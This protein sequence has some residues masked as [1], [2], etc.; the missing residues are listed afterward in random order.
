MSFK[1]LS[2]DEAM[3]HFLSYFDL[4]GEG[5]KVDRIV[6]VFARKYMHDN[7]NTVYK[8][9]TAAYTL[10]YLLMMLQTSLHNPQVQEKMTLSQFV[11]LARGL[12]DGENIPVET[13]NGIYARVQKAPLAIPS[14]EKAKQN[15]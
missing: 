1:K 2:I 6:Q 3:K 8:S 5:Q 12:N 4:P 13:L 7:P 14:S 10:S 9:A 11:D 15:L